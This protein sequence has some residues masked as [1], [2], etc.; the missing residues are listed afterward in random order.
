MPKRFGKYTLIRKL[1]VG[2]MAELFLAIQRSMAGFEKLIVIK[3]VLPH[4][5]QDKGFVEML[6]D[7]ARIA[8][9]LNH[10]NVAHIYDVGAFEGQYYIAMEHVHGEDLRAIV[11]QMKKKEV[12]SF[13]LEHAL[14]I[15]LG[16]CSGLAYAHDKKDLDG[17]PL[18]IVHRD[19]SPQNILVTFSGD[20]KLVDFG[21]A[22][23]GRSTHEDTKSGKLKGKI[24]YMSPEQAQGENLDARSDVFALG[25]ILFELSTG[26]RLFK[27]GTEFDT[28]RMIVEGSYPRPRTINPSLA[29]RLEE[30][31]MRALEKDR[32]KRY[33]TAREMQGDLEGFIR[34]ERL[35]VSSI[36]LGEWMQDLF[37]EKLAQQKQMLQEGRQLAEVIAAQVAE[38][39]AEA[40]QGS[41]VRTR[42]TSK[43]PWILLALVVLAAGAGV[44]WLL[45]RPAPRPRA[46]SG[47]GVIALESTPDGAA[48]WLD[49]DRRSERT[50]ARITGLPVG[51]SYTVKLTADGFQ[52]FTQ[53][54]QLTQTEHLAT[55]TA[56]LERP[57]AMSYGVI[58][59]RTTPARAQVLFDGVETGDVTPAT[60]GSIEPGVEHTL[61]LARDGYVTK[62]L[63]LSLR[64]GQVEDFSFELERLPLGPREAILRIVTVPD[65][66]RV[67][68]EG[69]W[70]D[71]GSPYEFRVEARRYRVIVAKGGFQTEDERLALPGGQVTERTIRLRRERP[72]DTTTTTT[73]TMQQDVPV[74]SGPGRLTFDARPW[75]NVSI[76]GARVGQTPIVN[77]ELPSGRHRITCTNPE[78][79]VTRN[80]TVTIE[81]GQTTRQRIDLQ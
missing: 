4:L 70:H 43:V 66:A 73:T 17:E 67:Q 15:A 75:C 23:A 62:T 30:I 53:R 55:V 13:P 65:D 47:P 80:V 61:A 33:Q 29:P 2:G 38:E 40:T 7:E 36:S 50:P 68:F 59:V 20:V 54:V 12:S 18:Q 27:S 52:P 21:I 1:A 34:A 19:V 60:L 10:P 3:R 31:I 72:R 56:T 9:T 44:A 35:A 41:G 81:P 26:R 28:M 14:A 6:L 24:P 37:A 8:A 48:I 25:V 51:A 22:K 11:R 64:A 32:T 45:T 78:L 79:N 16:C 77:R 42:R 49:G 46:R 57:S 5:A 74:P 76:D 58:N 63:T 39:E 71:T 69:E